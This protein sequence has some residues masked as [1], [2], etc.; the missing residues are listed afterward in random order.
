M[1]KFSFK[2]LKPMFISAFDKR[3]MLTTVLIMIFKELLMNTGVI[4]QLPYYFNK[5]PVS[6]FIIFGL[7]MFF[8]TL[9]A[10]SQA[11]IVLLIPLAF[12]TIPNGGLPLLVFLMCMTYIAMQISPTHICLAIV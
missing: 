11:M 7:I 2:E 1:S 6:A 9:L 4:A 12:A 8:G 5:L 10:G 3:I